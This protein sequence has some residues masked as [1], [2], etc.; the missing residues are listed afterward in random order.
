MRISSPQLS[1]AVLITALLLGCNK[2]DFGPDEGYTQRDANNNPTGSTDKTDWT[3]DQDWKKTEREL[4]KDSG[5]DLG[6]SQLGGVG[7]LSLYPSPVAQTAGL[8]IQPGPSRNPSTA[9]A[10]HGKL[11]IVDKKYRTVY[12]TS[13][14][15]R[16]GNVGNNYRLDLLPDKFKAGR[17]YRMY[18]IFYDD[19]NALYLKGHGDILIDK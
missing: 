2:V 16:A 13:I 15:T 1:A 12:T 19:Q 14:E 17:M 18:Y 9:P 4:F 5:V 6:Q 3:S 10:L 11:V 8:V 7:T